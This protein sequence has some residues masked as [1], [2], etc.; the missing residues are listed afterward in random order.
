M[1][2]IIV[3]TNDATGTEDSAN[4]D[5]R[6]QVNREVIARGRVEGH[7]RA[8]GWRPLLRRVAGAENQLDRLALEEFLAGRRLGDPWKDGDGA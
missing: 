3:I 4:Y 2:L 5:W 1:S 8:H 7:D 6:V